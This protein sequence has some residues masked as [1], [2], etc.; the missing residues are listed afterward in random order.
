VQYDGFELP[1]IDHEDLS[2]SPR[3][4]ALFYTRFLDMH[5]NT[6]K[7][8]QKPCC[9]NYLRILSPQAALAVL[10]FLGL[11]KDIEEIELHDYS[12]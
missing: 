10:D 5:R 11:F 9:D 12:H 3:I 2:E 1:F 4:S 8:T 7:L 6:K